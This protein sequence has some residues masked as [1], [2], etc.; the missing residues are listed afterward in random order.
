MYA[1]IRTAVTNILSK[2]SQWFNVHLPIIIFL[3]SMTNPF[4]WQFD[5]FSILVALERKRISQRVKNSIAHCVPGNFARWQAKLF[6]DWFQV[7]PISWYN[8]TGSRGSHKG[9][10]R[11]YNGTKCFWSLCWMLHMLCYFKWCF[12]YFWKTFVRIRILSV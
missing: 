6:P 2:I 5:N 10:A 3:V 1:K 4:D 7:L 11:S 8:P 9:I 12:S